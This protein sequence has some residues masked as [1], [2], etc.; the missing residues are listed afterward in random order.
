MGKVRMADIAQR[1]GVS[2]VTVHNALS[3]QKGVSDEMRTRI[4]AVAEELGYQQ[5]TA[6]KKRESTRSLKNIGVLISER[7][8]GGADTFYWKMYR[9]LSLIAMDKN[10]MVA[11]EALKHEAE[12]NLILPRL[13]DENTVEGLIIMGE[14]ERDYIRF[15]KNETDIPVIFLDFYD[16]TLAKDAVVTD[17]FYG[18]YLLTEYLFDKGFRKLA[19]I[20]SIH[21]TSS[22]MD[23]YCGFY[24]SLLEHGQELPAE[25]LIEDRDARGEVGF[26][27]PEHMPEAFVCN[28][29]LVAAFLIEKLEKEG[30]RVPEDISVVGFDNYLYPGLQD[31]KVTTYEVNMRAMV[32]IALEKVLKQLRNPNSGRGLNVVS[33]HIV[34]KESV[35]L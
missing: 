18:M 26:A 27:L 32:K 2:T 20:G 10:C 35:R 3:G 4:L 30:Y 15:L 1:V 9:E 8:L 31:K 28:C 14:I 13:L 29:D 23:R 19:Y 21:A 22:I 11:V 24:K 12:E 7:F 33:G 6:A 16:Y 17:N 25:W 34:E 5:I